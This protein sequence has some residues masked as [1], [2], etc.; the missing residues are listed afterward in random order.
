[1]KAITI[2]IA[3]AILSLQV[4]TLFAANDNAPVI[5]NRDYKALYDV[6]L[7]PITP[8]EATFDDAVEMSDFASL[9]PVTP[10]EVDFFEVVPESNFNLITLAP[11][12]PAT[13]DFNDDFDGVV[14][15]FGMLASV[16][17]TEADFE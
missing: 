9:V 14:V 11:V 5:P 15:N 16:T 1:M 13:A 7:A 6:R 10:A 17:P 12:A 8:A 2:I 3:A 4:S